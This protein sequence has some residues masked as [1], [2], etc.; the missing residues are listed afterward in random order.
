[1]FKFLCTF[2]NRMFMRVILNVRYRGF[3]FVLLVLFLSVVNYVRLL[4][5]FNDGF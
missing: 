4:L 1:M 5:Y 2:F 3:F